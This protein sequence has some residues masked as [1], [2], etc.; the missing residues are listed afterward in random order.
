MTNF[1][2][3]LNFMKAFGQ[4]IFMEENL[5]VLQNDKLLEL[6][7]TLNEEEFEELNVAMK[8]HN[9]IEVLDALGDLLFVLYGSGGAFGINIDEEFKKRFMKL[10]DFGKYKSTDTL[11]NVNILRK[12]PHQDMKYVFTFA[13]NNTI[14]LG[15]INRIRKSM[16]LFNEGVKSK[17]YEQIKIELVNTIY[18]VYEF[19][20]MYD[21]D[22]DN[23]FDDIYKSNM[24]KLCVSE[25]EAIKT[26]EW[27]K[28]NEQ[29]YKN[30]Q[31][32]QSDVAN[33]WVVFDATNGKILKS[34]N[35]SP[36][37]LKKYS[38]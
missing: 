15:Q 8:E 4:N 17:N 6:R 21:I 3:V 38:I 1:E 31:Y 2:K 13:E 23:I 35:Y 11:N 10:V 30:P 20:I 28:I 32:R 34:I 27:Y 7:I 5:D 14:L 12:I 18:N 19:T 29:R 9:Y 37:D 16:T 25:E 26:L 33:L 22:I 36:V 24:T